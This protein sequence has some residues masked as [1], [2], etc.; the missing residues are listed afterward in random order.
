[1]ME[2]IQFIGRVLPNSL[3]INMDIPEINW[4]W[5]EEGIDLSM[6]ISIVNSIISIDIKLS[7]FRNSYLTELYKRAF[8]LARA[9]INVVAFANGHGA[10]VMLDA[11]IPPN[12]VRTEIILDNPTLKPLCTAYS[13]DLSRKADFSTIFKIVLTDPQIFFALNDLIQ[14]ITIP[15]VSLVN[16]ARAMDTLKHSITPLAANDAQAW[17]QMRKA[18]QV[19]ETYLRFITKNS[20]KPRHGHPGFTSG[21][22][23]MEV[24]RRSWIIMNR[25]LEYKKRGSQSLP[26]A[27]FAML[28]N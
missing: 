6:T 17:E 19:D 1:M 2:K 28:M 22:I 4:K 20:K 16:C 27:H 23:T 24:T 12:G 14:S 11:Y 21:T 15:H 26:A 10:V 5:Q 9:S 13:L 7:H 18:L 25:F 8:D 3:I